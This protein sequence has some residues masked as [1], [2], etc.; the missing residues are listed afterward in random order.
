MI[1]NKIVDMFY[2]GPAGDSRSQIHELV[3]QIGL[4][5]IWVGDND[6]IHLVDNMGALWVNM[7]WRRGWKR[8]SAFKAFL[9]SKKPR[10]MIKSASEKTP[11]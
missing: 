10:Y 9:N 6:R 5:P 1:N 8:R 3:E 4:N 2:S 7:V 11:R